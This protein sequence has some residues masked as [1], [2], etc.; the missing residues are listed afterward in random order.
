M[1]A[2]Y[3]GT[4]PVQRSTFETLSAPSSSAPKL[5]HAA[6]IAAAP[7]KGRPAAVDL[8]PLQRIPRRDLHDGHRAK[9]MN[10]LVSF[11]SPCSLP[12]CSV[13]ALAEASAPARHASPR[14]SSSSIP[15]SSPRCR[16]VRTGAN[17]VPGSGLDRQRRRLTAKIRRTPSCAAALTADATRVNRAERSVVVGS[18]SNGPDLIGFCQST[19]TVSVAASSAP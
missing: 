12:L 7:G 18:F 3:K 11:P 10:P 19:G 1:A 6:A 8:F 17:P 16:Y 9:A 13:R 4:S 14:P 15:H 2:A 5:P